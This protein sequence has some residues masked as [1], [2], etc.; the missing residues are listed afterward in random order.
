[1]TM[2]KITI[3]NSVTYASSSQSEYVPSQDNKPK[4]LQRNASHASKANSTQTVY[5]KLSQKNRNFTKNITSEG[6]KIFK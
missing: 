6:F 1:M 5:E 3:D 2:Q 4:T